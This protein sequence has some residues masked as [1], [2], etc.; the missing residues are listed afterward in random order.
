MPF[1]SSLR[2]EDPIFPLATSLVEEEEETTNKKVLQI[3]AYIPKL[4]SHGISRTPTPSDSSDSQT[5]IVS[6]TD[7]YDT[8]EELNI[9]TTEEQIVTVNSDYFSTKYKSDNI[10][11]TKHTLAI[12]N[13]EEICLSKSERI[14]NQ[15]KIAMQE[16]LVNARIIEMYATCPNI[17]EETSSGSTGEQSQTVNGVIL[18]GL[19]HTKSI[20]EL[21]PKVQY[22]PLRGGP[23]D[24]GPTTHDEK[25]VYLQLL[26]SQLEELKTKQ[27]SLKHQDL[28]L[29]KQHRQ[30]HTKQTKHFGK[31]DCKQQMP[32]KQEI[33]QPKSEICQKVHLKEG[34]SEETSVKQGT[35]TQLCL[36]HETNL[37]VPVKIEPLQKLPTFQQLQKQISFPQQQNVTSKKDSTVQSSLTKNNICN[38]VKL[39]YLTDASVSGSSTSV[40]ADVSEDTQVTSME[41]KIKKNI[42]EQNELKKKLTIML[43]DQQ[44]MD[45]QV[46]VQHHNE[47]LRLHQH[48]LIQEQ[49]RQQASESTGKE[50]EILKLFVFQQQA[51]LTQQTAQVQ[52]CRQNYLIEKEKVETDLNTLKNSHSELVKK[53]E[54]MKMKQIICGTQSFISPQTPAKSISQSVCSLALETYSNE[55]NI[56]MSPLGSPELTSPSK[57]DHSIASI[58][59]ES[60]EH[61]SPDSASASDSRAMTCE[62]CQFLN[63]YGMRKKWCTKCDEL[64]TNQGAAKQ[65]LVSSKSAVDSSLHQSMSVLKLKSSRTKVTNSNKIQTVQVLSD[66]NY[67]L[68]LE[69]TAAENLPGAAFT[70]VGGENEHNNQNYL[71]L[72]KSSV[73]VESKQTHK[74]NSDLISDINDIG[75]S[76]NEPH[77]IEVQIVIPISTVSDSLSPVCNSEDLSPLIPYASQNVVRTNATR[78]CKTSVIT[79]EASADSSER[80]DCIQSSKHSEKVTFSLSTENEEV[81]DIVK[82]MLQVSRREKFKHINGIK[83]VRSHSQSEIYDQKVDELLEPTRVRHIRCRSHSELVTV[84]NESAGGTDNC[85]EGGSSAGDIEEA[86]EGVE[87]S[88]KCGK[89]RKLGRCLSVPGWFG[90]GL[91]IKKRRRY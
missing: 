5:S 51:L 58:L 8:F 17:Q 12:L 77:G 4:R 36:K 6:S 32:L 43:T 72:L 47:H 81:D 29:T 11:D 53:Y 10:T 57:K 31:Q 52:I 79:D 41:H 22:D 34:T 19:S 85:G 48:F 88:G 39:V 9:G 74:E 27:K 60:N 89:K 1:V 26:Q 37:Q 91:N 18:Q 35:S 86:E 38:K 28:R 75:K 78:Q 83:P 55:T 16:R 40:K 21:Q 46:S 64:Q 56:L 54:N 45:D 30:Q 3:P 25:L 15:A 49:L 44:K 76:T 65:I 61:L 24:P 69:T 14:C 68:D 42:C 2:E 67:L 80:P 13:T 7:S 84:H 59:Q 23:F 66:Y 71:S 50:E 87:D 20:V 73:K 63:D 82:D 33:N 62:S 70:S 90:K